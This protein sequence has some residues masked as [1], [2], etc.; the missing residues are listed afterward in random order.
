MKNILLN[1]FYAKHFSIILL[2]SV[3]IVGMLKFNF[4]RVVE[5]VSWFISNEMFSHL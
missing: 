5:I 3:I 1:L 4:P 2:L